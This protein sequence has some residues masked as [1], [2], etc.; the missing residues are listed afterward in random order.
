MHQN[1]FRTEALET[2]LLP[3]QEFLTDN[4][5]SLIGC[6]KNAFGPLLTVSKADLSFFDNLRQ[7]GLSKDPKGPLLQFQK[8]FFSADSDV[9]VSFLLIKTSRERH[10]SAPYLRL[11][12]SKST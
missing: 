9:P 7:F 12:N 1:Y 6:N 11:K 3:G 10:K 2:K 8:V 4:S 5:T